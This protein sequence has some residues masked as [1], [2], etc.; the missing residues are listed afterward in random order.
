MRRLEKNL[1]H[2]REM[3]RL[4]DRLLREAG[5]DVPAIPKTMDPVLVRYPVRVADKARAVAEAPA[6]G[7]EL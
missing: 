2:R 4:Y 7:I 3:G 6:H 1:A 5:W